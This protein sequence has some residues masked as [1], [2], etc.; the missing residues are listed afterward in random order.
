MVLATKRFVSE[1][2]QFTEQDVCFKDILVDI[3]FI[4]GVLISSELISH[5][6][7]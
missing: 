4:E 2:K 3:I 5:R 6:T 7:P 1:I